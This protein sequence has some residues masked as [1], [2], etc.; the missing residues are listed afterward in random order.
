MIK[1]YQFYLIKSYW[2]SLFFV[3]LIFFSLSIIL[4]IFE[5][6]S[7]FKDIKVNSLYPVF[8]TL[9]TAP[10]IVYETFPF[11]FF[12]STQFLF[13]RLMD[14][15]E[16]DIFKKISL[17]NIKLIG[18]LSISSF[19]ISLILV[20]I[21]YN[22]A[23]DLRFMYLEMKNK[24]SGDNK[25]LAV[26]TENGLWIKDEINGY[27]NIINAE[28]IDGKYLKRVTINQFSSD[29]TN[30]NNIVADE[31]N[32][33]NTDWLILRGSFSKINQS[34]KVKENVTFKS[35]FDAEQIKKMFSDLSS[36]NIIQ[37]NKLKKDYDN[38]GYSLTNINIHIQKLVAYPIYL[39][40]MTIFASVVM[41]NIKRNKSKLF[42]IVLGVLL[43]VLIYY[44]NYF[45]SLLGQNER[46]PEI[47][48]IWSPL[49]I[50]SLFCAIGLVRINEK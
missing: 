41:L 27:T 11:I 40:V 9:L 5:E 44:V 35:N 23:S 34:L 12:I 33:E 30:I 49:I 47:M 42:H 22:L 21:F 37:L 24:Y 14:K 38:L 32:I 45:S 10:T 16:L 28:K 43:S 8:L 48:S 3:S 25:Y 36:L 7:F 46:L 2:K 26:V 20:T 18:I 1:V 39:T 17:S 50:I 31:I 15:E 4:N 13:I 19:I 6:V 29:Y